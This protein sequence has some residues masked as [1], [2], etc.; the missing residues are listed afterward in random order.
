MTTWPIL[1]QYAGQA[2]LEYVADAV[3]WQ[4]MATEHHM[5]FH[6]G[7][8]V[9]DSEGNL[10]R[11]IEHADHIELQ[12]LGSRI[13]LQET[14]ALVQN[15]QADAGQCCVAKFSAT[16]IGECISALST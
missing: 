3:Q 1:L 15:H 9:I 5:H 14:I 11:P 16:S 13:T 6:R 2:E 12:P 8:R 7:D 4:R 10:Y